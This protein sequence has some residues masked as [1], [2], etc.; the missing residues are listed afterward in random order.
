MSTCFWLDKPSI[1]WSDFKEIWPFQLKDAAAYN[2]LTRLVILVTVVLLIIEQKHVYLLYGFAAVG[3]IAL[4]F[5]QKHPDK[6]P[7][8]C[9]YSQDLHDPGVHTQPITQERVYDPSLSTVTP[10]NPYG[11]PNPYNHCTAVNQKPLGPMQTEMQGDQFIDKLY[12]GASIVP[13]GLNYYRIPDPTLMARQPYPLT[14]LDA[15]TK[16]LGGWGNA[17][18]PSLR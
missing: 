16:P 2:A 13:P 18:T 17:N 5:R 15:V 6:D 3:V 4:V 8:P 11:N 12:T 14:S 9:T 1:L 10:C 7:G